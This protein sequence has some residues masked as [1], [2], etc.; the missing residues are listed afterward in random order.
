MEGWAFNCDG[1][2]YHIYRTDT[3]FPH[4]EKNVLGH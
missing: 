1:L 2:V 4:H 3:F